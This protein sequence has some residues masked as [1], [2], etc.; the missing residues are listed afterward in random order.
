[1]RRV[2]FVD[3]SWA[4]IETDGL[5]T[6][7]EDEAYGW[8]VVGDDL[9]EHEEQVERGT[10]RVNA[11]EERL[12]RLAPSYVD[13]A[14]SMNRRRNHQTPRPAADRRHVC[15]CPSSGRRPFVSGVQ[16]S[17]TNSAVSGVGFTGPTG[18]L[19]PP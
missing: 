8:E 1:M 19:L 9:D 15:G 13:W 2:A 16:W 11:L 5:S 6:A 10:D 4:D 7:D 3:A 14:H 12:L 18:L 17:H